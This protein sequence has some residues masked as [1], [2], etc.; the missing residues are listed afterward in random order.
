M[1]QELQF[2]GI[3][4]LAVVRCGG[5]SSKRIDAGAARVTMTLPV[6]TRRFRDGIGHVIGLLG[7]LAIIGVLSEACQSGPSRRPARTQ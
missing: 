6:E 7:S 5:C 2:I 1:G 3:K 4:L